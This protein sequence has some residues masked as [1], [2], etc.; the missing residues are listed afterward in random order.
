MNTSLFS[1][2]FKSLFG[3]Q[4]TPTA[5]QFVPI[6]ASDG[7]PAG[8][9]SMAN[10]MSLLG[11]EINKYSTIETPISDLHMNFPMKIITGTWNR[12]STANGPDSGTDYDGG[13]FVWIPCHIEANK[14]FGILIATAMTGSYQIKY[15]IT[16]RWYETWGTWK[17]L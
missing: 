14:S 11:V 8:I 6:T 2:M 10:L 9:S 13:T 7:T 17:E 16:Q 3:E 5:S 12:N 15:Y 4:I 1:N